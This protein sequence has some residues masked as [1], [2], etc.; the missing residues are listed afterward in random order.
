[1]EKLWLYC[2]QQLKEN[3]DIESFIGWKKYA[4]ICYE[5][6]NPENLKVAFFCGEEP[7]N[8]VRH[9]IRLGIRIEN[10][11]AFESDK[12]IFKKAVASLH[13]SY[14][15]LKIYKGKIENYAELQNTKFDIV[16]LDFTGTLIKEYKTVIKL[17]DLNAFT[18]MSVLIVNTTY[19]DKTEENINFLTKFFYHDTFF[20]ISII[21]GKERERE[22]GDTSFYR[23][24]GC[25]AYGI[26]EEVLYDIIDNNFESAYSAFQT[27]L[28]LDYAN[29]HKASYEVFKKEIIS[30]RLIKSDILRK[31]DEFLKKYHENLLQEY[32]EDGRRL[33]SCQFSDD[34]FMEINEMG[35]KISR[36]DSM[37]FTEVYLE[38]PYLHWEDNDYCDEDIKNIEFKEILTPEI[39]EIVENLKFLFKG[40][41]RFCDV[42]MEHLW[43]ELILNHYG[44]PYHTNIENHRRYSYTAKTRKMCLDIFTLDKC[45]ALYDWIPM[46]EYFMTDMKDKNRQMIT[47]MCIDAID[48]Q[49][50]HIVE[51]CFFGAALV[52]IDEF[53]WSQNKVLPNRI[54]INEVEGIEDSQ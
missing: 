2:Q 3:L 5:R 10:I 12:D 15:L 36:I 29:R 11:Y 35:S 47:R 50:I 18:D 1:M 9:L 53:E 28:I 7:E 20:E 14:P 6:K 41:F 52:G 51:E 24:E 37:K 8:D 48:K 54:N 23:A 49:L 33:S 31:K 39:I 34:K 19:P 17:F 44:H 25:D 22:D 38:S 13:S 42:P 40:Q 4:D 45:R 43:L 21:E 26:E 16:Y 27:S 32:F 46:F 30:D